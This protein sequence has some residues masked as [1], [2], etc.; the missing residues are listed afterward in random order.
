MTRNELDNATVATLRKLIGSKKGRKTMNVVR[1][2]YNAGM[3]KMGFDMMT[4][5]HGYNDCCDM[6]TL[7]NEAA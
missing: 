1:H 4:I 5:Y 2:R 6:A 3:D 7:E